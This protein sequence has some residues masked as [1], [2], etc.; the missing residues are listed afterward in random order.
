MVVG[1][2]IG[3]TGLGSGSLLT[4]LLILFGGM[5]ASLAVGTSL[6][7]SLLTKLYGSW[8]FY[9]RKLV[10]MEIVRDLSI[11]GLPGAMAG[12]FFVR[13]IGLRRSG[14]EDTILVR[15]I[16]IALI[17]VALLMIIRLL[18]EAL[19]P[20]TADRQIPIPRKLRRPLLILIG[21]AVGAG[22]TVT[23]VGSGAALVP[24]MVLFY[25]LDPG[26]LVG[27][28]VFMGTILSGIASISHVGL[29]HVSWRAVAGLLCGSIP[30]MWY[31]TRLH[32]RIPRQI[33]EGLIAAALLAMGVQIMNL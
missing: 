17:A 26:V 9:Q 4:P 22:V 3:L 19:R 7:F 15:L 23:S 31:A 12:A 18:P 25:R 1:F 8:D 32:G 24:A 21:L 5:P 11:G 14:A 30:A 10:N 2:L 16:G 27:T 20:G 28:N 6:V 13:Y 33:P 29:G